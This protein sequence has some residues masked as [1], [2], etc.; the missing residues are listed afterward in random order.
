MM[1]L[2][3]L[4]SWKSDGG[5]VDTAGKRACLH[6]NSSYQYHICITMRLWCY[7]EHNH[8]TS[9]PG[10]HLPALIGSFSRWHRFEH[11]ETNY[12]PVPLQVVTGHNGVNHHLKE[13]AKLRVSNGSTHSGTQ[14]TEILQH[15]TPVKPRK[16]F[17]MISFARISPLLWLNSSWIFFTADRP[18]SSSFPTKEKKKKNRKAGC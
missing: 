9:L 12:P 3:L 1:G 2:F 7:G 17:R 11:G 6:P 8:Q 15:S 4:G 16:L 13:A 18:S 14:L 10:F 5:G